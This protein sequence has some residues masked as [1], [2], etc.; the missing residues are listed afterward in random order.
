M[1]NKFNEVIVFIKVVLG[2]DHTNR[3]DATL[4]R[5]ELLAPPHFLHLENSFVI[6]TKRALHL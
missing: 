1:L 6:V 2:S 3:R 5:N 4:D